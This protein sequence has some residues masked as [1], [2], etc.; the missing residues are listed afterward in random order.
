MEKI[1]KPLIIVLII[2]FLLI[3]RYVVIN[4]NYFKLKTLYLN[5]I[6]ENQKYDN[7]VYDEYYNHI[8]IMFYEGTEEEVN[9]PEKINNKPVY[10]IDD[11]AFYGN[12]KM[13]K[14]I[15][16]KYVIRIG[17][18]VFIGNNS[19]EE[20]YL[21]DNITDLGPYSFDVCPKLKRI[22]VKKE[23]KTEKSLKKTKFYKYVQY[24]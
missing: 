23:S 15:I 10:S 16:P 24:K 6:K 20:V 18:Q 12:A 1:K 3:I 4:S 5:P 14:V 11:S 7:Y 19:L 17:H 2:I 13:K 22:Y 9:V 8:G 21:P